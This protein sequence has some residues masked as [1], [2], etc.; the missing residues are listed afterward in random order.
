[1]NTDD[2]VMYKVV[3]Q[4]LKARRVREFHVR[5]RVGRTSRNCKTRCQGTGSG[6]GA[7]QAIGA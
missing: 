2:L 1:M 5:R 4:E 7:D 6:A 3:A